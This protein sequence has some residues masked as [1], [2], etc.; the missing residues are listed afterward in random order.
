MT[1]WRRWPAHTN[2]AAPREVQAEVLR[3]AAKLGVPLRF[4]VGEAG[5]ARL[6]LPRDEPLRIEHLQA[7]FGEGDTVSISDRKGRPLV[8]FPGARQ[9]QVRRS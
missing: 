5:R 8:D 3:E 9:G 6:D 2:P 4:V 7:Q 1:K